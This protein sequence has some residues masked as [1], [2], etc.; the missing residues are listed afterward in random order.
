[1][2][3]LRPGD[4]LFPRALHAIRPEVE[5]LYALGDLTLLDRPIVAIVGSR[6]PTTY[7][8][9]VAYEAAR[10][11]ARAGLVVVSGMA[12][13]LDARAHRGALDGGGKTIAVLGCG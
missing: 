11:A 3:T 9:K 8:I 7:G 6:E 10:E 12:R 4:P 2:L 13:G 1:M 5:V